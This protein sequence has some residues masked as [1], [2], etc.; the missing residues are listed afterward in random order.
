MAQ[1]LLNTHLMT[2]FAF[3]FYAPSWLPLLLR[4]QRLCG[5]GHMDAAR[6]ACVWEQVWKNRAER[7]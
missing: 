1:L 6:H 2:H 7:A 5:L 4:Q 3:Y